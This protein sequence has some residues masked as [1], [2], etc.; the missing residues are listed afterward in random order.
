MSHVKYTKEV[1]QEAVNKSFSL[2]EVLRNLGFKTYSGSTCKHIR[3]RLIHFGISIVHFKLGMKG[4][5]SSKKKTALEVLHNRYIR[6]APTAQ[7]RR[8]LLDLGVPHNC[9]VCGVG[10]E[11][12]EKPLVLAIDHIDGNNLNNNKD[13]LRFLCP[14]CHSQTDTFGRKNAS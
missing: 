6:R 4:K 2:T 5:V 12:N 7:L 9:L 14:N 8:A 1:L 3:V 10:A 13:N 11:W